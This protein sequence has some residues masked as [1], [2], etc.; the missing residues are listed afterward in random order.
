[1]KTQ[2]GHLGTRA[3]SHLQVTQG[4][5]DSRVMF[6]AARRVWGHYSPCLGGGGV[7][8]HPEQKDVESV[9][10]MAGRCLH[11]RLP[12]APLQAYGHIDPSKCCCS[13]C[14]GYTAHGERSETGRVHRALGQREG[15]QLP[16]H[17]ITD[18]QKLHHR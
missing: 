6:T 17:I 11:L 15:L 7:N 5:S 10:I 18:A 4:E 14:A 9:F 13:Y 12:S 16:A 3:K 2:R 8:I 1:M